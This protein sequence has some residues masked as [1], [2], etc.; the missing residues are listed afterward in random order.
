MATQRLSSDWF[1]VDAFHG[2]WAMIEADINIYIHIRT[3]FNYD[4]YTS[5]S[6]KP[7]LPSISNSLD[8]NNI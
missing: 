2:M 3:T 5:P 6:Y 7:L 4:Q 1:R 8:V